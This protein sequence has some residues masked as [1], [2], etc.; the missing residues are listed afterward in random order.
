MR[1]EK[2]KEGKVKQ[3]TRDPSRK[4]TNDVP[5]L[6]AS[7]LVLDLKKHW[8]EIALLLVEVD[9]QEQTFSLT[10]NLQET[11]HLS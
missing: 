6:S 11:F 7:S 2:L 5:L 3:T 10:S 4:E 8:L 1:G 9:G